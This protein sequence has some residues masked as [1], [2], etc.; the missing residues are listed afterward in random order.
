[1]VLPPLVMFALMGKCAYTRR[2]L[3]WKRLVTPSKQLLMWLQQVRSAESCFERPNHMVTRIFFPPSMSFKSTGRWVK[4]RF[5]V[6]YLPFTSTFR[7]AMDTVTSF[8]TLM[9]MSLFKV[10]IV[11]YDGN[12][13]ALNKKTKS[14]TRD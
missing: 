9:V 12:D 11:R 6:P 5:R 13:D 2:S 10:F 8:G 7:E 4:S 3:Y 14:T 1:M